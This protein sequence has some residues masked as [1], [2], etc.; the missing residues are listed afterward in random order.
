MEIEPGDEI[1]DALGKL[2]RQSR[3]AGLL[4]ASEA[5]DDALISVFN[6]LFTDRQQRIDIA[7]EKPPAN[8]GRLQ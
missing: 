3:R 4:C 1:L 5:L 7:T 2:A 6:A 8:Y